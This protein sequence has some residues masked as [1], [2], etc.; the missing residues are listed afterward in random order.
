ML[1]FNPILNQKENTVK[2]S[3]YG[4]LSLFAL[5]FL[6]CGEEAK[7]KEYYSQHVEEAKAKVETCKKLEK[8]NEI[9]QLDC[10]NARSALFL[11]VDPSAKNPFDTKNDP[12]SF[13]LGNEKK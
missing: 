6:G 4:L 10:Q 1:Q 13:L 7:T 8:H 11:H 12:K 2:T 9:Q 5:V 3:L